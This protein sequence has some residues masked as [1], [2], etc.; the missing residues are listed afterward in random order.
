M[1]VASIAEPSRKPLGDLQCHSSIAM[2]LL[3][4][5]VYERKAKNKNSLHSRRSTRC[6]LRKG[7]QGSRCSKL[8]KCRL[9][10]VVAAA[11]KAATTLQL[12][13]T[14]LQKTSCCSSQ[15]TSRYVKNGCQTS[16]NKKS[17][18]HEK[19]SCSRENLTCIFVKSWLIRI[20]A[21]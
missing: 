5:P 9:V 1:K 14:S 11:F 10:S 3:K 18:N 12:T 19:I 7:D 15:A 6:V 8:D 16:L 2:L 21:S 13:T 17:D 4:R 20:G